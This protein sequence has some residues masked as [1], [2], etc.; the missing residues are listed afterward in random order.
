MP[1]RTPMVITSFAIQKS[2]QRGIAVKAS[3]REWSRRSWGLDAV[4]QPSLIP[5]LGNETSNWIGEHMT[6]FGMTCEH[7]W[8][9]MP[10][11]ST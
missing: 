11:P 7:V 1:V 10:Y 9:A 8:Q 6:V 4:C 3:D 2:A 5:L